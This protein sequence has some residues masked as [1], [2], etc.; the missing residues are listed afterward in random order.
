MSFTIGELS[1][2]QS[3]TFGPSRI[4]IA[5][6]GTS[7]GRISFLPACTSTSATYS[8]SVLH[9][10]PST[11][12]KF[13]Y[14]SSNLFSNTFAAGTPFLQQKVPTYNTATPFIIGHTAS[15][16][17]GEVSFELNP[18]N[19]NYTNTMDT[20]TSG[21]VGINHATMQAAY[22]TWKLTQN[23][24]TATQLVATGK[25][26]RVPPNPFSSA[27]AYGEL[28]AAQTASFCAG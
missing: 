24:G 17:T 4:D 23:N 14:I 26:S 8:L 9:V 5:W 6:D 19:T 1:T 20:I 13:L 2:S 25:L 15:T 11:E 16:A 28:V 18:S 7:S 22:Y 3:L 12:T 21:Q 27:G 10:F